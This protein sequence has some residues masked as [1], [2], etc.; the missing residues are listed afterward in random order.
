MHF[1]APCPCEDKYAIPVRFW[2]V[3]EGEM[4]DGNAALDQLN[5]L[6]CRWHQGS[7]GL[8]MEADQGINGLHRQVGILE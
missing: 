3:F 2:S 1:F 8:P 7:S 6:P 5:N 4:G